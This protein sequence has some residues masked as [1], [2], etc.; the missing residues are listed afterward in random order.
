M[1]TYGVE[2]VTTLR[3]DVPFHTFFLSRS[4]THSVARHRIDDRRHLLGSLLAGVLGGPHIV[5]G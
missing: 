2:A 3:Q 1:H 5:R 4:I